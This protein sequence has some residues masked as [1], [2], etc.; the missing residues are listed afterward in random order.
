MNIDL[1]ELTSFM[2][3]NRS[4]RNPNKKKKIKYITESDIHFQAT[5]YAVNKYMMEKNR[6]IVND[7]VKFLIKYYSEFLDNI[8]INDIKVSSLLKNRLIGEFHSFSISILHYIKDFDFSYTKNLKIK[9]SNDI[10]L[11]IDMFYLGVNGKEA[12]TI[13]FNRSGFY[14]IHPN[15]FPMYLVERY[16]KKE[17]NNISFSN[18]NSIIITPEN[19]SIKLYRPRNKIHQS[20]RKNK[21]HIV[22]N[23]NML[24]PIPNVNKRVCCMCPLRNRCEFKI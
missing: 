19:N 1:D 18:I 3:C 21:K 22:K 6:V 11:L 23:L 10:N 2:I 13:L 16:I 7:N 14:D 12:R 15:G 24:C 8:P 20:W 9:I 5:K 4:I 17:T